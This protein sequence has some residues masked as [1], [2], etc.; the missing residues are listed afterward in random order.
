MTR[1]ERS[2]GMIVFRPDKGG[3]DQYSFLLLDYGQHWDFPKGHVDA[4]ESDLAAAVRELRE[5][6]GI[7]DAQIIDG[8]SHEIT[9][10]FRGRG[11]QLVRK[12][13]IFFLARTKASG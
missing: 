8:F 13:V 12:T 9:Y 5:E 10:F 7:D 1:T 4:G 6:T 2:A 11:S 3:R